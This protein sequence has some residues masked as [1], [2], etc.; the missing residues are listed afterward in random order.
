M[1]RT[2]VPSKLKSLLGSL[3]AT[4]QELKVDGVAV[5]SEVATDLYES[6]DSPV[7]L[8]CEI[9]LRYGELAQLVQRSVDP[10]QYDDPLKFFND[11]QA[12]DFLRKVPFQVEGLDAR[13]S[14]P[15]SS[16]KQRRSVGRPT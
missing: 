9:L 4:T 11:R 3:V 1:D 16:G 15:E 10:S 13:G 12:V 6:L 14:A 7:S 2:R 8:S 5:L